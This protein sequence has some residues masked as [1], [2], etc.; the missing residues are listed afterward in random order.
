MSGTTAPL[1]AKNCTGLE[2]D[3]R[4]LFPAFVF[5]RFSSVPLTPAVR[6]A[7]KR[8]ARLVGELCAYQ[9]S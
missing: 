6:R 8:D 9:S 2:V 4:R 1:A 7:S 5:Y 3:S